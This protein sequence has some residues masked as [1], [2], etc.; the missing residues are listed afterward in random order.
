MS[1]IPS[2]VLKLISELT[3]CYENLTDAVK[4]ENRKKA[5]DATTDAIHIELD[6]SS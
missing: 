4:K 6:I 5:L 3:R 2:D 1:S